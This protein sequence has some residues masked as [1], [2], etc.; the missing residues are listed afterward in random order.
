M[1]NSKNNLEFTS[2]SRSKEK[3]DLLVSC[4]DGTN[5]Y[6]GIFGLTISSHHLLDEASFP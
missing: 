3:Q 1:F 2:Y 5:L 4:Y 6:F